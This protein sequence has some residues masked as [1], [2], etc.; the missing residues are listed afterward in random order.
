MNI[1]CSTCYVYGVKFDTKVFP[2]AVTLYASCKSKL[3]ESYVSVCRIG[4]K[5]KQPGLLQKLNMKCVSN[6]IWLVL[7]YRTKK[8]YYIIYV[9]AK[10]NLY[11]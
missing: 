6:C 1:V 5:A 8:F 10:L 4:D 3:V 7:Q 9:N 11:F 2:L